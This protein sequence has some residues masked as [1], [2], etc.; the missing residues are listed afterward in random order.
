[1]AQLAL[2]EDREGKIETETKNLLKQNQ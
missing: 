2:I 1:M